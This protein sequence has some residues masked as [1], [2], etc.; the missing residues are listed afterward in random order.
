MALQILVYDDSDVIRESLRTLLFE[1]PDFEVIAMLPNAETVETDVSELKP[2]V[3]LMDIDMPGVN[4]VEAV[5]RIRKLYPDL[6]I[7]MLT[8]FDFQ[9]YLCRSFRLHPETLCYRR[10]S[11]RYTQCVK[12]R[13]PYDRHSCQ[14]SIT[15]VADCSKSGRR[16]KAA[17]DDKGKRYFTITGKEL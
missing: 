6:P 7:I 4:G 16:R 9:S 15:D 3:V 17:I 12:W 5:K 1:E 14:K 13:C 8:V 2:H 10:D 11:C